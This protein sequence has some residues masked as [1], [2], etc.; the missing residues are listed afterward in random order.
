V[1][2]GLTLKPGRQKEHFLAVLAG[3][4]PELTERYRRL[5]P[6]RGQVPGAYGR[7]VL[8]RFAALAAESRLPARIPLALYEGL[9][10]PA[11]RAMVVLEHLH[12]LLE[13]R[14]QASGYGGAARALAERSE[15]AEA[16]QLEL[17][18]A[19]D[20]PAQAMEVL[21]EL[22]RTGRCGLLER[23]LSGGA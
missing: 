18:P 15:L 12:Y 9:L 17:F 7:G 1:F 3:F 14:G 4:H 16:R 8:R 20:F 2:G 11:Q 23:L 10:P 13:L 22:R 19:A 6:E 5:Y 21:E